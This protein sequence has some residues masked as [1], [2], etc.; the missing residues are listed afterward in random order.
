MK[1]LLALCFVL[2]AAAGLYAQEK[3]DVGKYV[4]ECISLFEKPVPAG[5]ERMDRNSYRKMD[6]KGNNIVVFV[7]NNRVIVSLYG[8]LFYST[9][10][11]AG[12]LG[13]FYTFFENNK[14]EYYGQDYYA[15]NQYDFYYRNDVHAVMG[16]NKREDGLIVANV[17]FT[18][19]RAYF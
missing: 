4:N 10:A 6:D 15:G 8:K 13:P 19:D 5:F 14:W 11:A 17:M 16:I 3:I 1:K 12:F 7:E 2:L 18:K 9:G